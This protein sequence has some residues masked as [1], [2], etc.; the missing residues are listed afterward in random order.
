MNSNDA[1]VDIIVPVWNERELFPKYYDELVARVNVPWR[2]LVVY[3]RPDDTTLEIA[4]PIAARDPRVVLVLNA[5]G[6]VA[7]AIRAGFA[8]AR[9][10]AVFV[11]AIDL[12][13]DLSLVNRMSELFYQDGFDLV[14]PSRYMPGGARAAGPWLQ[15]T[16][17]RLASVSLYRFAGL[18]IHDATNGSKL[19]RRSFVRQT[20]IES[21]AG[22]SVAL[23]LTAKAF[24]RGLRMAEL[25][26]NHAKRKA[27]QSRFRLFSWLPQ[28]LRW[29]LRALTV[30]LKKP[31]II[32]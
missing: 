32:I 26:S 3:D 30:P 28:Y 20:T 2:L 24:E 15:R 18:P 22:W 6:G 23:E 27:G 29:Y 17:S 1:S 19:Y 9:A 13:D 7:N 10:E 25:P 31:T 8:A 16:L 14:A 5:V 21:R 4:L 12:P 11:T